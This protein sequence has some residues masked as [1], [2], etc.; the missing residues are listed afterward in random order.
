MAVNAEPGITDSV[1]T[2]GQVVKPE[3]VKKAKAEKDVASTK[4]LDDIEESVEQQGEWFV[5]VGNKKPIKETQA[6]T[7]RHGLLRRKRTEDREVTTGYTDTRALVLRSMDTETDG[8]KREILVF[9]IVTPDGIAVK[10]FYKQQVENGRE[11]DYENEKQEY[12]ALKNLIGEEKPA[13]ESSEASSSAFQ[14]YDGVSVQLRGRM[15]V[16]LVGHLRSNQVTLEDF[17]KRVQESIRITESP[18][19][20]NLKTAQAQTE[21]AT[22]ASSAIT[23]LPPRE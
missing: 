12:R 4:L 8:G 2:A 6:V 18:H 23:S 21:L 10:R 1:E 3:D 19:K 9:T 15:S 17:Q 14:G 7:E 13:D 20:R 22:G 5:K 16:S 11:D